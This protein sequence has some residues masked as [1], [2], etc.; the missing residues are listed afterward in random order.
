MQYDSPSV[1]GLITQEQIRGLPLNGR[2][3]LE[4]AKLEPGVQ[5]SA[6]ANRN[7]TVVPVLGAPHRTS[8]AHAA[9]LTAAASRRWDSAARRWA[10]RRR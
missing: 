7:R 8:A 2:S 6:A 5:T 4:L 10:S 9:R 3:F 1:S